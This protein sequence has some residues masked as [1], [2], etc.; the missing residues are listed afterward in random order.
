MHERITWPTACTVTHAGV[1]TYLPGATFGP[2]RMRDYEFVWMV[3]GDATYRWN[4]EEF[5][6]PEGSVVLCRPGGE[7]FF[8]W[9]RNRRTRHAYFHF[10]LMGL[11]ADWPAVATWPFVR[12]PREGDILRPAF[13]Y[14]LTWSHRGSER[15][16]RLTALQMVAAF[17]LGQFD[18]SGIPRGSAPEPVALALQLIRR[19]LDEDMSSELRL[20]DL[21]GAAGVSQEHLCRLFRVSVRHSPSE[22]VRLVRLD[23]AMILLARSN[24][25]I[26]E[27]ATM[28]GFRSQFHFSRR[29]GEAF[30]MAPRAMRKRLDEGQTPPNL[31]VDHW[32]G[33][34]VPAGGD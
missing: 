28:C 12:R 22:T 15:L 6:A 16:C 4:A 8:T 14:I 17:V 13:R 7:D 27:I 31:L 24:Y 25:S 29:F 30:G 20:S 33:P 19:K 11:P 3:E 2:R 9:D 10:D 21:A 32:W 1:A 23:R 26:G 34:E 18:C 5:A